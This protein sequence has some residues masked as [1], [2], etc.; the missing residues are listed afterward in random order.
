MKL[1]FAKR[2]IYISRPAFTCSKLTT[3]T[4]EQKCEICSK[5]T[6]TPKRCQWHCLGV[7][8]VNFEHI[9]QLCSSASIV[10]FEHLIPATYKKPLTIFEKSLIVDFWLGSK[11]T[12]EYWNYSILT[13]TSCSDIHCSTDLWKRNDRFHCTK[14]TK[15]FIK[16]FLQ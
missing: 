8:I 15:F 16:D 14:K 13:K 10:N 4:L 1:I 11:Y 2:I 3:E 12:S 6:N 9:S 5:L 7:F